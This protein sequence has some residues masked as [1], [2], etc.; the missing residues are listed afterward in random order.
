MSAVLPALS[1][2]CVCRSVAAHVRGR[3]HSSVAQQGE[4]KFYL[5]RPLASLSLL[6][7][8]HLLVIK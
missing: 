4:L 8:H 2:E 3:S 7:P 5:L 1:K 6:W